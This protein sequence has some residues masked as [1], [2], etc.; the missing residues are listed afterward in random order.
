LAA[1][2]EAISKAVKVIKQRHNERSAD[3][4]NFEIC[5]TKYVAQRV[6]ITPVIYFLWTVL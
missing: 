5:Q 4:F 1:V 3:Q 6:Y 2:K